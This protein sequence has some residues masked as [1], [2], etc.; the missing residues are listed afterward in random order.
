M[1]AAFFELNDTG[2][3]SFSGEDAL[4]FL[5]AQLTSDVAALQSGRTQYSGYC[6]PKGRL[7]ATLLAW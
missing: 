5:H 3:I 7:L 2:I 6:T 4:S 1:A